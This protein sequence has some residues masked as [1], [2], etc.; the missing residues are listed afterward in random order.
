V[1]AYNLIYGVVRRIPRGRVATYG[2]VAFLAGLGRRARQ[3]GYALRRLP[4]GSGLPWQRV[5]NARGFIS[6]HPDPTFA[7]LQRSLLESEGVRFNQSGGVSL[8]RFG[9]RPRRR[10]L[11]LGGDGCV[12]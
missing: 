6:V 11:I 4:E 1:D 10:P 7:Q 3:V 9:W 8:E 12:P 2:Q 5:I